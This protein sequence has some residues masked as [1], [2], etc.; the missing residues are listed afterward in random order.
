MLN[1]FQDEKELHQLL[2][3]I[4]SHCEAGRHDNIAAVLLGERS[5][6]EEGEDQEERQ[7]LKALEGKYDALKDKLLIEVRF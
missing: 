5:R 1:F 6:S 3:V 2:K 4:S 7:L